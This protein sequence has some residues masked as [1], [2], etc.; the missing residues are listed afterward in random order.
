MSR[1]ITRLAKFS[2][3][4]FVFYLI[5][6]RI[7]FLLVNIYK[8]S[9]NP[10][11]IQNDIRREAIRATEQPVIKANPPLQQQQQQE[12]QSIASNNTKNIKHL[13]RKKNVRGKK[14]P[15]RRKNFGPLEWNSSPD[16]K[17]VLLWTGYGPLQEGM[18]LWRRVLSDIGNLVFV[19]CVL[20]YAK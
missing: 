6:W 14:I 15:F 5:L 9:A 10:T 8:Y 4:I 3:L 17:K 7:V 2:F 1:L 18:L 20:V 13:Q 16:Y 19:Y 12:Q 11:N